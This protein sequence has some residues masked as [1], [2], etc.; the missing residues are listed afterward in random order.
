MKI[1]ILL[2]N[3]EGNKQ[4]LETLLEEAQYDLL[5]IQEPWINRHT[6][7]TYCPRGSKYHL[8]HS[9]EGRAA[10]Y[11]NRRFEIGQ[12]EYEAT[13]DHCRV[14]F[15]GLGNSGLELW[16][17]YNP[18][19]DRALLQG[20]LAR[21]APAYPAVLAGDFNLHHPQWDQYGRYD[22][23]AEALLELAVQWDLDLRTPA[24]TI[25]RAPQGSQQGRTSTI[26][27]FWATIGLP[28]AYYGLEFRGKSDHYPQVLEVYTS[29]PPIP[30]PQPQ[31]W[32]WKM[33]KESRVEAEAAYIPLRMGLGDP[34]PQGLKARV[35]ETAG[36]EKAFDQL[37][38]ELQRVAEAATPRKKANRGIGSPWWSEEVKE[39]QEEARRAERECR[40][41]QSGHSREKLGQSL[42][43]LTATIN[44]EKTKVWRATLQKA[45][46]HP[47]LLWSL[48]RW[49]RCKS[50]NPLEPSKLPT[51]TG[52]PGG[53]DLSTHQ[54]KARALA[55]RFFPSPEADLT[56]IQDPDLQEQWDPRFSIEEK[57]TTRDIEATLSKISPWK[58]LGDDYLP[59]GLLKACGR[60]LF[61]VLAVLAE[62]CFRLGWF[63]GRFK[64]AK[65]VVLQKPGKTPD[66]YRTPGGYRPIALLP[67]VGKLI[68]AI[69]AKR[70]TSAAEAHGL[71]PAEQMGNREHRS[72]E[73][74]IRLV[75]AQVQEAWRQRATASLLQLDISG[76]FDTVNH[77]RLLATLR[78]Q[79]FPRWVVVWVRAWL[80]N[81]VAILHFDGQQTGDIPV[82]AG[83]PQGSPLSPVLFILYIASLYKALKQDHPT[84]SI[85]GFADDTN[86]LAFGKHSAA[87]TRQLERAW[88]TCL[89]WASTRGMAFAA[90]KC[91]LIHFNKGR[92]QWQDPISLA[93]PG[94]GRGYSVVKP[95]GSARFLGVWLDWKL[96]WRAHCQAVER[97][98]RT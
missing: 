96:S 61:E 71:L 55:G 40:V 88:K 59:T 9:L 28:T 92:R 33:M 15:P 44:R 64:R 54:D 77:T 29:G 7:S 14:W 66:T 2:W 5:A 30:L 25:T 81:R 67:T 17:I 13:R 72:T 56:D 10:I 35:K 46:H 69:V 31:G 23:K 49:A 73:L 50:F 52:P 24:G 38:E 47:E 34:G 41:A 6:K 36:L 51:F 48:E 78:E 84:I 83:V 19:D 85:A 57:V 87:N 62:A 20:L 1:R 93:H 76:A 82:V 63:P 95:V 53:P 39:A 8:I 43:A 60:P 75:V 80:S 22:R 86:L 37:I 45:T 65:T 32:N 27:H 42:R 70:V 74:A 21:Q 4:A 97:K 90:Q 58:A 26:D 11:V 12:W 3:I 89:Q 18:L 98:L 91:E 68:E 94:G 79:G 16:S